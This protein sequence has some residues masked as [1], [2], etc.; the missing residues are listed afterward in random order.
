MRELSYLYILYTYLKAV[1]S[2][3]YGILILNYSMVE[4]ML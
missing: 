2:L 3:V 4:I 1:I